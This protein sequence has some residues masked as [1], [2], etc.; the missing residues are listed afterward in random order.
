MKKDKKFTKYQERGA[1]HQQ[2]MKRSIFTFNAFVHLR[3]QQV[4]KLIPKNRKIKLLDVGCGEGALLSLIKQK[5]KASVVG[6]DP[7]VESFKSINSLKI[8]KGSAYKLPFKPSSF[9]YIIS[10]EVIEHLSQTKKYLLEINR[11]LKPKGR[12]IITTLVKLSETPEDK[13]HVK[14]YTP[15]ELKN[16]LN[17]YFDKVTIKTSHPAWLKKLYTFTFVKISKYHLDIFRWLINL[18]VLTI[19]SNPFNLKLGQLS[20]QIA[21]CQNKK[22]LK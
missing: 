17:Q 3:Y 10:T 8:I 22:A 5:T 18:I 21:I 14:E 6:I 13:M 1:Y 7:E 4:L 15:L 11:V 20:Q 16:L 12:L 2:Q 19:K 9:D